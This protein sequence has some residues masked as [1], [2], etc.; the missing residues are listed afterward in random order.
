MNWKPSTE[1]LLTIAEFGHA[2]APVA[3]IAA[4]L[5]VSEDEYSTWTKRLVATRTLSVDE[6]ERML[7]QPR[8]IQDLRREHARMQGERLFEREPEEGA[9]AE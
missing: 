2:R 9:A 5:G 1:Q 7:Y 4:A 3:K 6:R 8:S